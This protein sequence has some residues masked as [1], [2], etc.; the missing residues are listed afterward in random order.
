MS[1]TNRAQRE[2]W[3]E[4]MGPKWVSL[5]ETF[6]RHLAEVGDLA[7]QTAAPQAGEA[8]L[9]IGCGAGSLA[10][11]LAGMAGRVLGVDISRPMLDAAEARARAAG[12]G[13]VSFQLA[14]AQAD[15]L[16]EQ[17]FDLVFSRFGVMFFEDPAA[18]F[19]NIR[20][21][22]KPSGRLAFVCWGKL[23]DNPQWS[24]PMTILAA[25]L[26][27]PE[28]RPPHAPGPMAFDDPDYVRDLLTRAGWHDISITETHPVV[29]NE[30]LEQ[31][32][33][34]ALEL[35]P[36]SALLRERQPSAETIAELQAEIGRA[37]AGKLKDGRVHLESTVYAVTAKVSA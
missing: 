33:R 21:A 31:A 19:A 2:Y 7:V 13:N 9:E 25:R 24:I 34:T 35:G 18:A 28:P 23:A 29:M 32:T 4:L 14:D 3:N 37:F 16:P 12:I 6:D 10:V 30:P 36:A 27:R 15:P 1:E 17:T 8:V 22:A 20:R 26:G 11:R 5:S